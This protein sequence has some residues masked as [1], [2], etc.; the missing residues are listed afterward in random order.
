MCELRERS[1][2]AVTPEEFNAQVAQI[3]SWAELQEKQKKRRAK[4]LKAAEKLAKL[5]AEANKPG[6]GGR[7]WQ[8]RKSLKRK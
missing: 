3:V 2:E 8:A 4:A 7:Q 1:Q 5:L 6:P